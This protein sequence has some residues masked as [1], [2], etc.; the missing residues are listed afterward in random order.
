MLS[1]SLSFP[2]RLSSPRGLL[3]APSSQFL[4]PLPASPPFPI[5]I[6]THLC[7]LHVSFA[8]SVRL[9]SDSFIFSF[10][11]PFRLNRSSSLGLFPLIVCFVVWSLNSSSA[12]SAS[13]L[14][15]SYLDIHSPGAWFKPEELAYSFPLGL[16]FECCCEVFVLWIHASSLA[17]NFA[18]PGEKT[19]GRILKMRTST[20][21]H[22]DDEEAL[23]QSVISAIEASP[24]RR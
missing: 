10:T 7:Y 5:S 4:P 23:T 8:R 12:A 16:N 11:R 9:S 13:P 20:D 19:D 1:L 18:L 22:S 3:S 17:M 24:Q 21:S 14:I 6:Q 2:P 15:F